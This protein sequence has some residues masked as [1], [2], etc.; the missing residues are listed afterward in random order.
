MNNDVIVMR[1][2][3]VIAAEINAVKRQVA[4]NC[5]SAAIEIGR[6]LTEAKALVPFGR[7]GEWLEENCAYSQSTA[8]NLMRLCEEYGE[9]A[10]VRIQSRYRFGTSIT[11]SIPVVS[12]NQ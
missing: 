12:D 6:L 5:L 2:E 1:N 10:Q 3:T 9:Q 4:R 11:I 7:W 8:N